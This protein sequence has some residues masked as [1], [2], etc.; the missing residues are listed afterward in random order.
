MNLNKKSPLEVSGAHNPLKNN[1]TLDTGVLTPDGP[2]DPNNRIIALD[3]LRGIALLGILLVNIYEFASPTLLFD[4][5]VGMA[6]PAFTGWHASLD[7][8]ILWITWLF[9][10]GKMR[11]LFSILFGAGVIMLTDRYETT[12]RAGRAASIFYRRNLWL[13]AIGLCHGFFLFPGDILVDYAL[14]AMIVLFFLRRLTARYLF[15]IGIALWVLLGTIGIMN[16][17][18]VRDT[19]KAATALQVAQQAGIH[20]TKEQSALINDAAKEEQAAVSGLQQQIRAGRLSYWEGRH[21]RYNNEIGFLMLKGNGLFIS[22]LGAMIFGMGLYKSGFLNNQM[23]V[24]TY[25]TVMLIGYATAF[26]ITGFGLW[27]LQQSQFSAVI[28]SKWLWI[29][30]CTQLAAGTLANLSLMLLL[31]RVNFLKKFFQPFADVGRMALS[32]YILTSLICGWIFSWGPLKLYGKL[33]FFEWYYIVAIVW[34]FNLIFSSIWL[35]YFRMGPV[36]WLWRSLTYW[37]LQPI[38][39]KRAQSSR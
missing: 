36:E 5:P 3:A 28:F 16:A 25:V 39:I 10:E 26:I 35:I 30:Y 31:I 11:S 12:G 37:K 29:P 6:K 24:S 22:Y 4:V 15:I 9:A 34:C 21:D 19:L 8:F 27:Q 14:L 13:L 17:F 38:S 20:A 1:S 32:N 7:K 2:M 18:G 33:E 23:P